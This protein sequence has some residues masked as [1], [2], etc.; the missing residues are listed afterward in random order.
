MMDN[1]N[2]IDFASVLGAAV[3][4][5]KNSLC[6]LLR[7][8][9]NLTQSINTEDQLIR[10][11]L[12]SAHYEAARLNTSLMQLLSLYRSGLDN[13][14]VNI[15][16]HYVDD[17]VDEL[18]A[19]NQGYLQQK[20]RDIK[21]EQQAELQWYFDVDLLGILLN[22]MLINAMRYC[23][24]TIMLKVAKQDDYLVIQVEDDGPGFPADMLAATQISM[25]HF[26]I[27]HGRTGLG[28][29]FAR[30]IAQ[31]HTR[32]EKQGYIALSNGGTLGGG[33]FTLKLP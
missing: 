6:L 31:A 19:N 11:E 3:H 15:D 25:Q 28:L 1:N 12:A 24:N 10:D 8:I 14:P 9:E 2:K 30:L 18:L 21:V 5:M 32:G 22:D 27:S 23:R 29:F 20:N 16:Q 4:D 7:T 33:V 17:F 26:D 13:L